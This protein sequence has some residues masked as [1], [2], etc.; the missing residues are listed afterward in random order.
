SDGSVG[1]EGFVGI[2]VEPTLARFGRGDDRVLGGAGMGAGVAV[3]RAV[4][5]ERPPALL[6]RPEVYPVG[7]DLHA[8]LALSPQ[9][10]LHLLDRADVRA[11]LPWHLA[12][13]RW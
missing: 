9:R 1:S 7:A 12:P 4:T 8:L 2:A 5:A 6:A 3:R 10:T 13:L 11:R